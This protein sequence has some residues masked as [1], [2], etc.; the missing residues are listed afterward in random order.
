MET[1]SGSYLTL[2]LIGWLAIVVLGAIL[3]VKQ[4]ITVFRNYND[5]GLAF[6]VTLSPVALFYIFSFV[7][8]GLDTLATYVIIGIEALL[9]GWIVIR[10]FQDNDSLV[11]ALVAFVTKISLSFLFIINFL[12]FVAPKGET[13]AK[14]ASVR[15]IAL[16]F[17]LI[18][19]PIVFTLVKKPEGLF[20]PRRVMEYRG[21]SS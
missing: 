6:L 3:G 8:G 13:M 5:L 18:V 11:L 19:T 4:R 16:T 1:F 2:L 15:H 14:R 21:L 7:T 12:N 20:N 17:L 10:T 9:L